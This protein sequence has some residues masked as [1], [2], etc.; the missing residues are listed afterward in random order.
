MFKDVW[1]LGKE[2]PQLRP[3]VNPACLSVRNI[4]YH[5]PRPLA[6]GAFF[7][8]PRSPPRRPLSPYMTGRQEKETS[9]FY[10]MCEFMASHQEF[11][12][13]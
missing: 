7:A 13:P 5:A 11:T 4:R 1:A 3:S 8:L 12:H 9:Q 10:Q 6:L 2:D